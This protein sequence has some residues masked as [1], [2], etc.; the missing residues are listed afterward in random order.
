MPDN[1]L[2]HRRAQSSPRSAWPR[3]SPRTPSAS[4][5]GSNTAGP[6][7]RRA[8]RSRRVSPRSKAPRGASRS[9]AAWPRK[10]RCCARWSSPA[11]T[12]CCRATPTAER[13]ASSPA[14][15]PTLA[16]SGRRPISPTRSG[17]RSRSRRTRASCGSRRRPIPV[18][19]S[20]TLRQSARLR[21]RTACSLSSTTPSQRHIFSNRSRSAPMSSCT[22]PRNISVDTRTRS[23]ASSRRQILTSATNSRSSRTQPARCPDRSTATSCCVASRRSRCAWT[24]TARPPRSSRLLSRPTRRWRGCCIRGSPPTPVMPSPSARCGPSVA[25]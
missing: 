12:W 4:T 25:W 23:V 17:S 2:T 9:P 7:T 19:A 5:P 13:S 20:W 3:R 18:S 15:T 16:S 22:P 14:C 8:P 24:V 10:T 6:A 1:R 21:T 11:I